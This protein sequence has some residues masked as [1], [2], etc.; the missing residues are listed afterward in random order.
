MSKRCLG[1]ECRPKWRPYHSRH[2]IFL[3]VP[4]ELVSRDKDRRSTFLR[5][6]DISLNLKRCTACAKCRYGYVEF[7]E[8]YRDT[9]RGVKRR[10]CR[11]WRSQFERKRRIYT[12]RPNGAEE[13]QVSTSTWSYFRFEGHQMGINLKL[14]NF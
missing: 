13:S 10:D 5:I 6:A 12:F 2:F 7:R 9:L 8:T 3:F 14:N 1:Y 4:Q 11:L